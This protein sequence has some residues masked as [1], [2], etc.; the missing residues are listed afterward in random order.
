VVTVLYIFIFS[1]VV[2]VALYIYEDIRLIAL[3]RAI[4]GYDDQGRKRSGF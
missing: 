4:E 2:I 1:L 3:K